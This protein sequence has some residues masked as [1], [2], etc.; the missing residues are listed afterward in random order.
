MAEWRGIVEAD[1]YA[2]REVG[3]EADEPG[4]LL[5]IG[6]AGLA[7]DLPVHHFELHRRTA[8]DDAFHDGGHLVRR[9]RVDDLRTIVNELGLVLIGPFSCRAIG[10]VAIVMLPDG[11]AVTVLNA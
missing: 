4:I 11:A 5:V 1:E 6:G 8:L 3:R 2:D 10:A 7:S 9:H